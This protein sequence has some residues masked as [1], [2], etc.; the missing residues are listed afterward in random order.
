MGLVL[1]LFLVL[2]PREREDAPGARSLARA[3]RVIRA[4]ARA[5]A[6]ARVRVRVRV[7]RVGVWLEG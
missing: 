2:L 1:Q 6:R 3:V 5:R 4:R 7:R